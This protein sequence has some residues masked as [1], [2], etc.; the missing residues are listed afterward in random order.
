LGRYLAAR[1]V[2]SALALLAVL[3]LVFVITHLLGDPV[4]IVLPRTAPAA[5]VQALREQLH[6][7]DPFLVQLKDFLVGAA[8][9]SFG[10]SFWQRQPALGIV[11]GRLPATIYLSFMAFLIL[12]PL[13][14]AVGL[15]AAIRPG[16]LLDRFLSALSFVSIS[17]VDFWLALMLILVFSVYLKLLPT[18]G[19]GGIDHVILPALTLALLSAGSLAL[20]TRASVIE[21][22]SKSYIAA[23]R[24]RGV[25]ERRVI[26]R[27]GLRNALIPIV[28]VCGGLLN[29]FLGGV[30]ICEVVFGWPGTG[31]LAIQAIDQRDLPLIEAVVFVGGVIAITLNLIVDLLYAVLNPKVR[32]M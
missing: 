17:V 9:G 27:H 15:L 14:L 20:V 21:E 8:S 4:R 1:L 31:L 18:S 3:V 23:A 12:V 26:I 13:G 28:T 24:A 32:L 16:S 5:Q 11:M 30:V 19:F 25:P 2:H 10:T 29:T 22:L 6:L 7:N